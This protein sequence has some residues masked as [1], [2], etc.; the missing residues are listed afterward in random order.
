MLRQQSLELDEAQARKPGP[1]PLLELPPLDRSRGPGWPPDSASTA[2]TLPISEKFEKEKEK[3]DEEYDPFA[4]RQVERPVSDVGAL[5][6]L[7]KCSLGTGI[8]AMPMAFRSAG[9]AVGLVGTALVGYICTHCVHILVDCSQRL[10]R[11]LKVPSMDYPATA[12]AAFTSGPERL[13]SL[14]PVA[15]WFVSAGLFATYYSSITIYII[16][17][18]A[19]LKQVGDYHS[20]SDA[21]RFDVRIYTAMLAPLVLAKGQLRHLKTLVPFSM[22]ANL[23]IVTGF[24]VTLYYMFVD[25]PPLEDRRLLPSSITA[26]PVF[27][28][29]TIYAMEGVGAVMPVENNMRNPTHFSGCPG[30]VNTA[31]VLVCTLYCVVGFFGYYK[32]G[33]DTMGSI[34]LN[35]PVHDILAQV[36]KLAVAASSFLSYGLQLYIVVD[37][38]WKP[39]AARIDPVYHNVGERILRVALVLGTVALAVAVPN[40]GPAISLVGAVCFSTLGLL[41]PAVIESV[42]LW[43]EP[44]ALGWM[45][46]KL[47]KNALL[48]ALSFLALVTGTIS[49]ITEII[50]NYGLE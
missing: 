20:T 37:I 38:A 19:T 43:Q 50:E 47:L 8:L 35:L 39:L 23:C 48:V 13:R 24:A 45:R 21:T 22:L 15:S 44:G 5:M 46:W 9:L 41:Y 10:C 28:T 27:L 49:S 25:L 16:F 2:S 12:S 7:L 14:A 17:I 29:T 30:V 36:V 26:L 34:T 4:H 42:V 11:R 3:Q 33:E 32:Y 6:H 40:L 18:A 31:M 1:L